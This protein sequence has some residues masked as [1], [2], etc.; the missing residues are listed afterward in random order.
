MIQYPSDWQLKPP[1]EKTRFFITSYPESDADNFRDNLNC[2]APRPVEKN[3]T[4]QMAEADIIKALS[5]GLPGFKLI[6]S[7]NPKWNN[8]SSY[9]IEYSC[10]Q[11]R[12]N[13]T[14]YLHMLQKVAIIDG[15]LYALTFT[16]EDP[17]YKKNIGTV[18]KMI[19]S[20]K[21]K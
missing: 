7:S 20:F 2:I 15:M 4:I 5:E 21:V 6:K 12:E 19:E 14:Y 10:T 9:E 16:S 8:V 17:F 13:Y 11:T 3:V 18:R 1:T